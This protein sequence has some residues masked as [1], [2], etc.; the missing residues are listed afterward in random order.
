MSV[1]PPTANQMA[2]ARRL[3]NRWSDLGK[4]CD[5]CRFYQSSILG[6]QFARCTHPG[7]RVSYADISR[8]TDLQGY[9]GTAGTW[10]EP[11]DAIE[12]LT[13]RVCLGEGCVGILS[14]PECH[15]IGLDLKRPAVD[16]TAE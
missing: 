2:N 9:C 6:P 3:L 4:P 1:T 15:G 5:H 10:F 12:Q 7:G 13:C 14:C 8:A 16:Q 11:E